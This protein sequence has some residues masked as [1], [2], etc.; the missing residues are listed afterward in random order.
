MLF[1]LSDEDAVVFGEAG[2]FFFFVFVFAGVS[3]VCVET[4]VGVVVVADAALHFL[5]L[6]GPRFV[7]VP[8]L[9]LY[10]R[11]GSRRLNVNVRTHFDRF[12][13]MS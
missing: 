1:W 9:F 6:Y 7:P 12:E 11:F 13:L 8:V 2:G 3:V 10:F 5:F 4:V